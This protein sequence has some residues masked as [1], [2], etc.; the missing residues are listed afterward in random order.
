[1]SPKC[2]ENIEMIKTSSYD[3]S[4]NTISVDICIFF[5]LPTH[6]LINLR[7]NPISIIYLGLINEQSIGVSTLTSRSHDTALTR[8]ESIC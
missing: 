2:A 1:M 6:Y 4:H 3:S 7:I 5:K 8:Y